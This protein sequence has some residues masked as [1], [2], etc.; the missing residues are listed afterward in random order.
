MNDKELKVEIGDLNMTS[1]DPLMHVFVN[2]VKFVPEQNDAKR[3]ADMT[4]RIQDYANKLEAEYLIR[5]KN[6]ALGKKGEEITFPKFTDFMDE[7]EWQSIREQGGTFKHGGF[8][9]T[10]EPY[11]EEKKE[12]I[13]I[14]GVGLGV[15]KCVYSFNSSKEI[16]LVKYKS[17]IETA[18]K[19]VVNGDFDIRIKDNELCKWTDEDMRKCFNESRL[20]HPMAGFKHD[21][22][23]DYIKSL[24]K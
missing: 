21:T 5:T 1:E 16:D 23:E 18:V 4:A 20:I 2:G 8:K 11:I 12:R 3:D 24:N 22:F 19:L 9:F 10:V 14:S 6:I 7:K 17:A 15:G 13:S